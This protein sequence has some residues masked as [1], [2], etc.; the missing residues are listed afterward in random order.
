MIVMD[1]MEE[2]RDFY[3]A[4]PDSEKIWINRK[5]NMTMKYEFTDACLIGV[6]QID[7]EHR[8]LFH[9]IG[10]AHNLLESEMIQDKYDHIREIIEKLKQ[11]SEEHFR[12]EEDYMIQIQHPELE[13]QKQQHVFFEQRINELDIIGMSEAQEETLDELLTFLLRWL[14]R[15]IIGSDTLIG[16]LKPKEVFYEGIFT[17][18]FMTGIFLI[19]EEHRELFRIVDD[20]MALMRDDYALDKYDQILQLLAELKDYAMHHFQD[21]EEYMESVHYDGLEAQ[22]EAHR[23]FMEYL[24]EVDLEDVDNNQQGSL[25][26]LMDFLVRW[27]TEHILRMDKRIPAEEN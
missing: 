25:E 10:E 22:K 18:E 19:D 23:M 27:L 17:E 2:K 5:E 1:S 9:L 11:Y 26:N 21:E 8:E 13:H 14:Y 3:A 15:H 12:H 4:F 7:E 24:E 20:V 6:E 16:K